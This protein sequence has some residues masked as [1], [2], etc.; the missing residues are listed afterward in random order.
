MAFPLILSTGASSVLHFV[1]RMFLTWYSPEAIAAAMPGGI[2]NFTIMS[3][4]IGTAGYVNTFVAQYYGAKRDDR[5]G[6]SLWQGLYVSVAGAVL[7]LIVSFFS[8]PLFEWIGHPEEVRALEASYFAIL[9][10]WGIFPIAA[11]AFAGYFS[12]R[13]ENWP[14]MWANAVALVV[15][16]ALD[17]VMIF[18]KLGFAETG[19]VGAG[20]ATVIAGAFV[21]LFYVVLIFR[22]SNEKRYR[23]LSGFRIDTELLARML[24]YGAPSGVQFLIDMSGFSVFILLVGRIGMIELAA[25]NVAFNINTLAFM[26]MIGFGIAISVL[27]GQYQGEENP[28]QAQ[29]SVYSGAHICFIYMSLIAIT[30]VVFPGVYMSA[31]AARA[32][33]DTFASIRSIVVVL[34]RFVAVYTLFD[35]LNI[36]F[37]SALKGAGDTRFVMFMIVAVSVLGLTVPTLIAVM[38]FHAGIFVAWVMVSFYIAALGISFYTRFLTGKWRSM[39]VIEAMEVPI[40]MT[41]PDVPAPESEV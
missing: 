21:C 36:V 1:D 5:I 7:V 40:R 27:V 29:R 20:R 9:S 16:I 17:Y 11:S 15:N 38:V 30:Y 28:K 22:R 3:F 26:P 13:G 32:D 41:Y 33:A 39:K 19:I 31:F 34:L 4:F 25:S 23:V 10:R 24:K 8:T 18:G 12:G 37:A 6:P 35:T 14:V 2:L